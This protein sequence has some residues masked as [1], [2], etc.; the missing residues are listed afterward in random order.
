[1][2]SMRMNFSLFV[3]CLTVACVALSGTSQAGPT[4]YSDPVTDAS[5]LRGHE[6]YALLAPPAWTGIWQ[7][8]STTYLCGIEEPFQTF[9]SMDTVCTDDPFFLVV[10]LAHHITCTGSI[11][12]DSAEASCQGSREI[13]PDC[14]EIQIMEFT[15]S[16]NGD[17]AEFMSMSSL[18]YEGA[19]CGGLENFCVRSETNTTRIAPAP[20]N[21][22]ITAVETMR[23]GTLKARYR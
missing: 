3:A 21:C 16:R 20:E 1:M 22:G 7:T 6:D 14:T 13:L 5:L 19:G 2:H 4:D 10:Q 12:D 8:E 23:W 9:T 17:N 15:A 11:D 18:T